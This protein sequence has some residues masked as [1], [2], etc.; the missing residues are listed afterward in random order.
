MRIR[1][2]GRVGSQE[3]LEEEEEEEEHDEE[4]DN[5]FYAIDLS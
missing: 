4:K 5:H 3:D 1:R 2:R